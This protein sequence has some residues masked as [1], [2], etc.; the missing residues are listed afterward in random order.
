MNF[1]FVIFTSEP[2]PLTSPPPLQKNTQHHPLLLC[3]SPSP[4]PPVSLRLPRCNHGGDE[5]E[6][7]FSEK[8]EASPGT[9]APLLVRHS[10]RCI[11]LHP[12]VHPQD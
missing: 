1:T 11:N 2:L 5:D 4:I 10:G 8:G 12:G 9:L 3:R 6:V 7:P